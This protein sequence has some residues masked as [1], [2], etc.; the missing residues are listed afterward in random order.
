MYFTLKRYTLSEARTAGP[1][2][3]VTVTYCDAYVWRPPVYTRMP[4]MIPMRV[5]AAATA[6]DSVIAAAREPMRRS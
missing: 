6:T 4:G 1:F 3:E 5:R 2:V